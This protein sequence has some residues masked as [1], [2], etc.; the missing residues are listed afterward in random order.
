MTRYNFNLAL[1]RCIYD[2]YFA[3]FSHY[4]NVCVRFLRIEKYNIQSQCNNFVI[5][6]SIIKIFSMI[7]VPFFVIM[8]NILMC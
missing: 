1:K 2:L 6:K 7:Y 5:C 3:K 8:S 4:D